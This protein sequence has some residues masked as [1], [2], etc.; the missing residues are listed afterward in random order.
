[1]CGPGRDFPA[2]A[3]PDTELRALENEY[4]DSTARASFLAVLAAVRAPQ[5]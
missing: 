4:C 1:V 3:D 5:A 2:G